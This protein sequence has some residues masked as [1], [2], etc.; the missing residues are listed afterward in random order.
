MATVEALATADGI[1]PQTLESLYTVVDAEALDRLFAHRARSP[2][3]ERTVVS[4]TAGEKVVCVGDGT[5][6]CVC[7]SGRD[8]DGDDDAVGDRADG[9]R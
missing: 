6:V 9:C 5:D 2:G 7:D 1:D 3:E 4:L 8:A